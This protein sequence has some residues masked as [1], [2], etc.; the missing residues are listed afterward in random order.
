MA[1]YLMWPDHKYREKTKHRQEDKGQ[2]C[3]SGKQVPG[4]VCRIDE[5]RRESVGRMINQK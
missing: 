5:R 1:T 4:F 3:I 2:E